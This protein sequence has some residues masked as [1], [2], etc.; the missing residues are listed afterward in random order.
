MMERKNLPFRIN[1]EGY[2]LN[3][4]GKI[5]AKDSKKGFIIFPG[6]GINNN[7]NIE[8]GMIRETLEE[9]GITP[10]N[11]K[12]LGVLKIIWKPNWIKTKKQKERYKKFQG[13]EMH[14]FK[15]ITGKK[16]LNNINQEDVW[17][18]KKFMEIQ[19]VINFIEKS[20]PFHE[21]IKEYR[22]TQLRYLNNMLKE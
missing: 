18:G 13:D 19:D 10:K 8:S 3:E 6:G 7:E 5:L 20:R 22:E 9:T 1:C 11:L 12:K 14:F 21:S 16:S 4:N 2:F 15:G 17:K